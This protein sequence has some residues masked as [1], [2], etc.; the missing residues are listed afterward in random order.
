MKFKAIFLFG[1]IVVSAGWLGLELKLLADGWTAVRLLDQA[2]KKQETANNH[3]EGEI[4][5]LRVSKA[6]IEALYTRLSDTMIASRGTSSL[7]IN[8]TPMAPLNSD[9]SAF[10]AAGIAGFTQA[11]LIVQPVRV[12][13]GEMSIIYEA[14]TASLEFHRLVPLLAEQENADLFLYFDKVLLSRPPSI[15]PFSTDPTYL[16][17]RLTIRLLTGK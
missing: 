4:E 3:V 11:G 12:P 15:P 9:G 13:N 17:T 16:D 5:G 1:A 6:R 7:H 8:S 10:E 2:N 14:G